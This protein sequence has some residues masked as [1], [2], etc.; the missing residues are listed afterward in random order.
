VGKEKVMAKKVTRGAAPEILNT[1]MAEFSNVG[2]LFVRLIMD[3][4]V[5]S[6]NKMVSG[7]I[8]AYLLMPVDVIPDWI[9]GI[10]KLDDLILL[11]VAFDSMLNRVPERVI[12]EH[13]DGDPALLN[14]VRGVVRK[15]AGFVPDRVEEAL[16]PTAH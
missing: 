13:W 15:V 9:P 12:A 1:V 4:R 16:F 2:K 11:A 3:P 14:K 10:G 5:P 8:A 7:A 6:R